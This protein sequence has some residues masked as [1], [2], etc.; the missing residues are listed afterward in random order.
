[1]NTTDKSTHWDTV[2]WVQQEHLLLTNIFIF[3]SF[4]G[5]A[6]VV[7]AV[8]VLPNSS[9]SVEQGKHNCQAGSTVLGMP[10]HHVSAGLNQGFSTSY[11]ASY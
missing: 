1:M 10:P 9:H 11:Q 7:A 5:V 4:S 6:D 2:F 8:S 3:Q